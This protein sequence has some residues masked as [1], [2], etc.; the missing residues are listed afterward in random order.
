MPIYVN[1]VEITDEQVLREM[2]HHPAPDQPSALQMAAEALTVRELLL[3][4]YVREGLGTRED[5]PKAEPIADDARIDALLEKVITVPVAEEDHLRRYY[6]NNRQQF[7]WDGEALSF[8]EARKT[9]ADYL[10]GTAWLQAVSQYIKILAGRA[11]LV[12]IELECAD[13]PLVQ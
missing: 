6:E 4:A 5:D 3:Q 9:I 12:G 8:D 7:V 11:K 10:T 1:E 13:S 2:Q